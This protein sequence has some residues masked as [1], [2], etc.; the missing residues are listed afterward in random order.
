MNTE[1]QNLINSNLSKTGPLDKISLAEVKGVFDLMLKQ[2]TGQ[3][4][5]FSTNIP[6]DTSMS[7]MGTQRCNSNFVFVPVSANRYR[8]FG[9]FIRLV[10]DGSHTPDFSAFIKDISS[11]NFDNTNDKINIVYFTFDGADY[12]YSILQTDGNPSPGAID[13]TPPSVSSMAVTNTNRNKIVVAYNEPLDATSVP[14]FSNYTPSG[15]KSVIGIAISGSVVTLTVDSNYSFGDAITLAYTLGT[16]KIRDIAG[17]NAP[18][19][20]A[21]TVA[22]GITSGGTQLNTPGSFAAAVISGTQIDLSWTDTNSAPNETNVKVYR[23]TAN[24]F[25]TASL[26]AT[27]VANS[28]SHSDTGLTAGTL[29]YYWIVAGGNGTTTTDSN[30]ATTSATTTGGGYDTDAQNIINGLIAGGETVSTPRQDAINTWVLAYKSNGW[31]TGF[32]G[33]YGLGALAGGHRVNLKNPATLANFNGGGYVHDANGF[34]GN[35]TSSYCDTFID[36][37]TFASANACTF[38]VYSKQATSPT[39]NGFDVGLWNPSK[40]VSLAVDYTN[41][42]IGRL[43]DDSIQVTENPVVTTIGVFG[44]TRLNATTLQA[45][46]GTTTIGPAGGTNAQPL[47]SGNIYLNAVNNAGTAGVFTDMQMS[48]FLCFEIGF[49][50]TAWA[51]LKTVNDALLT[52]FGR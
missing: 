26:I 32:K 35:G 30:T 4:I 20:S 52:A 51:S 6:F 1:L 49:D 50:A 10:G 44:I 27:K 34:A 41:T 23:N 29:Y 28:V 13:T 42:L 33:G 46:R 36:P 14:A 19:F 48:L 24:N 5:A 40:Q 45:Y 8:G 15:G 37:S 22:N 43:G 16:N 39:Q 11:P 17:N 7:Y 3:D 2:Q 9:T 38:L 25:G 31:W 12:V 18:P 47:P 21:T